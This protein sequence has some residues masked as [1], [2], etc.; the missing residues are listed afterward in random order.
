MKDRQFVGILK[1]NE[2]ERKKWHM[3]GGSIFLILYIVFSSICENRYKVVKNSSFFG[4]EG[5]KSL[6]GFST[7]SYIDKD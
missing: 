7:S 4:G 6:L 5:G 3:V 2:G 1:E